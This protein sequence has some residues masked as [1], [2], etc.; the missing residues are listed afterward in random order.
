[1]RVT[2]QTAVFGGGCFWCTEAIFLKLKGV[3][4]VTPGYSGGIMDNPSYK[5]VCRGNTGHAEVIKIEFD[6]KII[7]YKKL[8]EIFFV[9]HDPTT[10][11]RQGNDIGNQYRSIILAANPKQEKEAKDYIEELAIKKVYKNQIVTEIKPLTK[12]FEA[13]NYH[14]NYYDNNQN[15]PYCQIVI[16]PKLAKFREKYAQLTSPAVVGKVA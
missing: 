5:E 2:T 3:K 12:F 6:P 11:N 9:F 14:K 10:L 16:S 8:L 7:S 13:E 15:Q 4:S 1:M